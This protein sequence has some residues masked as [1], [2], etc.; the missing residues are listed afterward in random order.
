MGRF[1]QATG[2]DDPHDQCILAFW[3]VRGMVAVRRAGRPRLARPQAPDRELHH[4]A[5]GNG[6]CQDAPVPRS[7]VDGGGVYLR[8]AGPDLHV[9][10][11]ETPMDLLR[12]P[13]FG[14]KLVTLMAAFVLVLQIAMVGQRSL[15]M[16]IRLFAAQSF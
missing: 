1:Y 12:N 14:D 10:L 4:G 13:E 8:C 5:C 9:P 7:R 6:Q 16:N 3:A 11:L 15:V 2:P